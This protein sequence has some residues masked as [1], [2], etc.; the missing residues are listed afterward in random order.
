[1]GFNMSCNSGHGDSLPV[2]AGFHSPTLI[3]S[4]PTSL[5]FPLRLNPI[6][7]SEGG[8]NSRYNTTRHS[9]SRSSCLKREVKSRSYHNPPSGYEEPKTGGHDLRVKVSRKKKVRFAVPAGPHNDKSMKNGI[10]YDVGEN[11]R[12]NTTETTRAAPVRR[13]EHSDITYAPRSRK[14]RRWR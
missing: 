7:H 5:I 3:S 8:N 1:M 9:S 6:E 12:T 13:T 2:I 4:D 11:Y 14:S 10:P